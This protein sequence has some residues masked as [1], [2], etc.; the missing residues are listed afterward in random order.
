SCPPAGTG[1]EPQVETTVAS[2]TRPCSP[3]QPRVTSQRSRSARLR[4]PRATMFMQAPRSIS[5]G[6]A[7]GA[8]FHPRL[9]EGAELLLRPRR[10]AA[11]RPGMPAPADE[12]V[13]GHVV[14]ELVH[15]LAAVAL[16]V[17]DLLADLA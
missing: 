6:R 10:R 7:G 9:D 14:D 4:R 17:L 11:A 1:A 12:R 5:G 16:R 2:A 15:R 13:L 3:S 8:G